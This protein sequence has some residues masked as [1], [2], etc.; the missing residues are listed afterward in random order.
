MDSH[1]RSQVVFHLTGRRPGADAHEG[2]VSGLRPALLAAYRDL[3][4][5]RYD[6]PVVFCGGEE[7]VQSLS[8]VVDRVLRKLAPEGVTGESM[9]RRVLKVER[10][11]RRLVSAG[12][13]GSLTELWDKASD[14]LGA[15][16]DDVFARDVRSARAALGL[17]GEVAGCDASLPAR[18]MRHA[19]SVVQREKA[20]AARQR[21]DGLVIRL[22]DILRA[23]YMR[24]EQALQQ[25]ALQASFGGAHHGLF[26]FGAMSKLLQRVGPPGGLGDRRRARVEQ[27]R[28]VLT[29][30][31][32][33]ASAGELEGRG[34]PGGVHEFSFETPAAAL[35]A[36]RA[37]LP[38]LV[39]LLKALQVAELE[40]EGSYMEELHD[41]IFAALDESGVTAQDLRFFPDYLVC[42]GGNGQGEPA[43]LAEAL[44]SG[45]PLKVVVQVEDLIEEAAPGRGQFTFGM[46]SAQLA[47][48]AMSFDE[49][50]V[51]QTTA[52]NLLQLRSRLQHGLR[53][54]GPALFSIYAG[55][56]EGSLP[57]YLASA[58]A[59]Q[60]RAFPAFTYDPGAGPD[61]ASRLSLENNPQPERDWPVEKFAYADQD[62][63]SVTEDVAFTFVDFVACDPRYAGHFAVAP[64]AAW[65]DS[66]IPADQWLD[67][68]PRDAASGVP[69]V[70]AVDD[71]DLLCR[72]VVDDRLIRS[73]IRC[74]EGWHRL[75]ELGGIHDSRAERLLAREREAWEEQRQRELQAAPAAAVAPQAVAAAQESVPAAS[76]PAPT[77]AAEPAR[78]P[79]EAYI[80]TVRCS[81]CNEC[82]QLNPRMFAYNE[83]KQA[84]IADLKAGTYAQLV[85][86]AE[87]CQVSV[88]HPGKPWDMS[89]PGLEE[90]IERAKP[91]L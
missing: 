18:F 9:R 85:Q 42:I 11:I 22:G 16:A 36:F 49:V 26:D 7:Y 47:S 34:E 33:F 28:S 23:D 69:Y 37:R 68:P 54:A 14:A 75:Q 71:A 51:L 58:A 45:V 39:Q 72:L 30:Q 73:A 91:F 31:R 77:S 48:A 35:A 88:I 74:R 52:S 61:L 2:A 78:N 40:V 1:L 89:E 82:T 32:F 62:L 38:D 17:D 55:P 27:A 13:R 24:S 84:Y 43:N 6:F 44:S 8:R 10:E 21:I 66:M 67:D 12:A 65:N 80:E 63:Q 64:R 50:F 81:T 53:H 90:L 29:A 4:S 56:A 76:V 57:G 46:R 15:Q 60:S 5:L 20:R 83:N 70:L 3:D 41:P 79:D 19:W 25:P 87:S 59:M 86:A